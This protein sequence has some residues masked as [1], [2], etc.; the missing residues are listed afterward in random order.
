MRALM[1]FALNFVLIIS[2]VFA[3]SFVRN[4]AAIDTNFKNWGLFNTV[5][6]SHINIE[7]AWKY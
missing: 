2:L 7:S 4:P 5:S 6:S 3:N 1:L